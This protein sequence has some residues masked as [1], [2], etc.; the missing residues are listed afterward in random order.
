MGFAGS[1]WFARPKGIRS[2][3]EGMKRPTGRWVYE[4]GTLHIPDILAP[5]R[6]NSSVARAGAARYFK[7]ASWS[8]K[9]H[10]S[11]H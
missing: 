1:F 7:R 10:C 9:E 2:D 4:N 3:R 11:A 8:R 5:S 6:P